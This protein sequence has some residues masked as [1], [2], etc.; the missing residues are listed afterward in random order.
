MAGIWYNEWCIL[1][2]LLSYLTCTPHGS[3][4]MYTKLVV[5]NSMAQT[6]H[7]STYETVDLFNR[8]S[9]HQFFYVAFTPY[10]EKFYFFYLIK[11][12]VVTT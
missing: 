7:R 10:L 9:Q 12:S 4:P 5:N 2:D 6:V 8:V 3:R 11:I 1:H